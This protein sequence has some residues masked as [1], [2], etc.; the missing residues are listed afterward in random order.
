MKKKI[1]NKS[2]VIKQTSKCIKRKRFLH[3]FIKVGLRTPND[4]SPNFPP[5]P[6]PVPSVASCLKLDLQMVYGEPLRKKIIS[7]NLVYGPAYPVTIFWRV[8]KIVYS[9][10]ITVKSRNSCLYEPAHLRFL[11]F[12]ILQEFFDFTGFSELCKN[13]LTLQD[14][15]DSSRNFRHQMCGPII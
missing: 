8:M 9:Q 10:E 5:N 2:Y 4:S 14:F 3:F 15:L 11:N 1:L 7:I 13:F 12:L 6:I